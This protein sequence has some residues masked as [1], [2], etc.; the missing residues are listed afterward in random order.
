MGIVTRVPTCVTFH[1]IS[2]GRLACPFGKLRG[3]TQDEHVHTR[4][5]QEPCSRDAVPLRAAV[6]L[7][8]NRHGP[9][10]GET[11]GKSSRTITSP[12]QGRFPSRGARANADPLR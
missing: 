5:T 3:S 10:K 11:L 9:V 4:P 2:R 12:K 6:S 1:H 8:G 7:D